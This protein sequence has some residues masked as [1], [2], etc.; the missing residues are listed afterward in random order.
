M[1]EENQRK[2]NAERENKGE[3]GKGR[4][5]EKTVKYPCNI[6]CT[7][8]SILRVE[9]KKEFITAIQSYLI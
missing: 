1:K 3:N 8:S 9:G 4:K 7:F 5:G 2:K 6:I